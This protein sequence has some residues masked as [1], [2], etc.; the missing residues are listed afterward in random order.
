LVLLLIIQSRTFA[1]FSAIEKAFAGRMF[2]RHAIHQTTNDT[3]H[4]LFLFLLWLTALC[5][6]CATSEFKMY[7]I[8]GELHIQ[9]HTDWEVAT[10]YNVCHSYAENSMESNFTAVV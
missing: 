6:L 3:M 10:L 4:N 9:C 1:T 2:C 5:L 7:P 8:Y